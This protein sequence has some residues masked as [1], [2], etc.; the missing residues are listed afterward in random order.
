M[1]VNL[2]KKKELQRAKMDC[3][4]IVRVAAGCTVVYG[5]NCTV[6]YTWMDG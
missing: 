6:N 4:V 5:P 3:R 2:L 1:K